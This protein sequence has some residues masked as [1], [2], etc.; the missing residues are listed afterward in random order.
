[1]HTRY[2]M[3]ASV[4]RK[5]FTLI[6]MVAVIGIIVIIMAVALPAFSTI[7]AENNVKNASQLV[8]SL[9]EIAHARS[10][11]IR[12]IAYGVLFYVDPSSHQQVS[13]FI[14]AL[15]YPIAEDEIW[16][17]VINRFIIDTEDRSVIMGD[18]V[19]IAPK[20]I[21]IWEDEDLFNFD[22]Q[23]GKQR[24]LFAIIFARGKRF[25]IRPF[26]LYDSDGDNDGLGDITKLPVSDTFGENGGVLKDI[27]SDDKDK[28]RE[29]TTD[30]GF[31]VYD[32]ILF[33]EFSLNYLDLVPFLS[34]YLTRDGKIISLERGNDGIR[35]SK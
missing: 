9:L 13:V 14:D 33:Q 25:Q 2:F 21:L 29:I 23:T 6:E 3:K 12:H 24:N 27:V 22:Y 5:S 18:R 32:E 16:P 31:V 1:M 20:E 19:R 8:S 15:P 30:W 34:Y 10:L 11:H 4:F 28:R 35:T 7:L 26:I 17:D